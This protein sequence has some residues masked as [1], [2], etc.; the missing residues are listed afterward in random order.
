MSTY[1][2]L[3]PGASFRICR[4]LIRDMLRIAFSY[5]V[6]PEDRAVS[7]LHLNTPVT[8]ITLSD[9]WTKL[10]I[11]SSSFTKKIFDGFTFDSDNDRIY[12]DADGRIN[13]SLTA[14]FTGAAGIQITSGLS[15]VAT[16]SM[17]LFIDGNLILETPLSFTALD[18]IQMYGANG[19]LVDS[20]D[21]DLLQPGSYYELFSKAGSEET[22]TVTLNSLNTTIKKD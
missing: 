16:V 21:E 2:V 20:N 22:P 8:G 4:K 1:R 10:P 18:K 19:I 17:G 7:H 13:E 11:S 5:S 15:S 14:F 9:E 6:A 12:W 3:P